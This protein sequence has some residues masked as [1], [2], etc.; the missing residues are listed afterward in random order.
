MTRYAANTKVPVR[1]SRDEIERTIV[2]Y[3]AGGFGHVRDEDSG[4]AA[5]QFR[6]DGRYVRFEMPIDPDPKKERQ[7]W[8]AL[9]L[10]IKAKLEAAA[11]GIL[12]FEESFYAHIVM[13]NGRTLYETTREQVALEYERSGGNVPLLPGAP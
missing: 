10:V 11:S 5:V 2:R 8:R 12:T 6:K 3:G 13:P 4:K 9:A 1:R 7:K